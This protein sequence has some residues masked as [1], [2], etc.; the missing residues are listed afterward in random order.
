MFLTTDC[1]KKCRKN[2][3]IY[4][5]KMA[6]YRNCGYLWM[7]ICLLRHESRH[8][9]G[10]RCAK[11]TYML[12]RDIV[13]IKFL[14]VIAQLV[15]HFAGS[16]NVGSS[17]LPGSTFFNGVVAQ[18]VERLVRNEKVGSSILLFSTICNAEMRYRFY[19]SLWRRSGFW[20]R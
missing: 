11:L 7:V 17:I 18:L 2:H 9:V 1:R 3:A 20:S 5:A 10:I 8:H 15:E 6:G 4:Y 14:G 16:E 19:D 13:S 12:N